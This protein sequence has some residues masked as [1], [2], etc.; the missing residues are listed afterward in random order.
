VGYF[1]LPAAL[2]VIAAFVSPQH[3][4]WLV[5]IGGTLAVVAVGVAVAAERRRGVAVA[6]QPLTLIG[7]GFCFVLAGEVMHALGSGFPSSAD[8]VAVVSYPLLIAGLVR[9]T[10]ARF[11]ESALDTLLVAA[12]VPASMG[13]FGWL[14]LVEAIRHWV[15]GADGHAWAAAAFL[16]VDGLALAIITRLAVFF[17]GKPAAYQLLLGA[18]ACSLGSHVSR[19]VGSVTDLV[20]APFGSQGLML[21]CFALVAGAALH[22]SMRRASRAGTTPARPVGRGQVVMLMVA[23]LFGPAIVV[24]RYADRGSWVILAAFGP[25]VVSLLVVAH[26]SR[27]IRERQR[28]E[29]ASNHDPLTGLPNRSCLHDRLELALN[30]VDAHDTPFSVMFLDLDRFKNVNDS[31]GHDCGDDLLR[32]VAHRLTAAVR[33]G[34][35]VA[36]ISGDEFGVLLPGADADVAMEVAAR[37]LA[38]FRRPFTIAGR[39]L[40]MS[41][42]IGV[43]VHPEHGED[44]ESLLRHADAAMYRS[45]S[46]GR[47]TVRV[48]DGKMESLAQ[49]QLAVEN[50]LR[51]ALG[52]GRLTLHYQPRVDVRTGHVAAVE[53][54][55][56]WNHP[57]QGLIPPGAFL[58]VAEETGLIAAMGERVLMEA[59]QQAADWRAD[60]HPD[61][62]VSVNVSAR[63]F[64]V[65]DL[66]AVVASALEA[67]GLPAQA[68]EL[69][70]SESIGLDPDGPVRPAL[71]QLQAMG[72]RCS[73]DDFGT[74]H[75]SISYLNEYPVQS[76]NLDR[77]FVERIGPDDDAPM[78]RA[79]TAMAH[80]LG[81]RAVAKGVETPEQLAFLRTHGCDEAQGF[82][83]ARPLPAD[84]LET[85]LVSAAPPA[86]GV[87]LLPE[88]AGVVPMIRAWDEA[89][90]GGYLWELTAEDTADRRRRGGVI[91]DDEMPGGRRTLMLAACGGVV[92]VPILLGLGAGGGL[93]PVVQARLQDASA[94]LGA[95]QPSSMPKNAGRHVVDPAG[96]N[97]SP[98]DHG[99]HGSKSRGA[100]TSGVGPSTPS[101]GSASSGGAGAG[102]HS[103]TGN[104][105]TTSTRPAPAATGRRHGSSSSTPGK[106]TGKRSPTK[107]SRPTTGPG[108]RGN[109]HPTSKPHPSHTPPKGQTGPTSPKGKTAPSTTTTTASTAPATTAPG[110][111]H[112]PGGKP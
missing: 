59:C 30:R 77:R 66:P 110:H 88:A 41:P 42:S 108:P 15:P 61:L 101:T 99:G 34:D 25:A 51:D 10:R 49:R 22:P 84:L 54:L 27:M 103:G 109:G 48:Y 102:G 23:V 60:G 85:F 7:L 16:V 5:T 80:H 87:R 100:L 90:L 105:A 86:S 39:S 43:A 14:P 71:A 73:I 18:F 107:T 98:Q 53:A 104:G 36:R 24:W 65:Q 9:L 92:A 93:P 37:M 74:G 91:D 45:K 40:F 3:A 62:V 29:F 63:Q 58:R 11:R 83:F 52:T 97:G 81:M 28:L 33:Q 32:A 21:L 64:Q 6:R 106:G 56:R 1:G 111:G 96:T 44:V 75:S 89:A 68:L 13:V 4:Q 31:L 55:V 47:N 12:I 78:V 2:A 20:P 26:L 69:E 82:L 79:L 50:G 94:A 112:G 76:I 38:Q 35:T 17:R 70:L 46:A 67:A 19:T 95:S 8:A 57:V 72:V